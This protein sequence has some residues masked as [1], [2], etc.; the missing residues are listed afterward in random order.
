MNSMT[1]LSA[2]MNDAERT[3]ERWKEAR[4]GGVRAVVSRR[5]GLA[6]N[7]ATRDLQIAGS[8]MSIASPKEAGDL[9]DSPDQREEW[10]GSRTLRLEEERIPTS[11]TTEVA[12]LAGTI[13]VHT[14]PGVAA[15]VTAHTPRC[16]GD[17]VSGQRK[18]CSQ[19][20][21]F[22]RRVPLISDVHTALSQAIQDAT[23]E[24]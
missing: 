18:Q 1:W 9:P 6:T 12:S 10:R 15:N 2:I 8:A 21:W 19:L 24:Y 7:T 22:S 14:R 5:W 20:L 23:A 3:K 13:L 16:G 17:I 4:G 11:T